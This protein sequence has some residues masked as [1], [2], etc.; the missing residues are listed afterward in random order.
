MKPALIFLALLLL[1]CRNVSKDESGGF[2]ITGYK[3]V[4]IEKCEYI[5]IENS[6][7]G[8]NNYSISLT[9]KGNCK[10]HPK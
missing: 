3:T 7:I 5:V 2:K 1:G 6:S 9:H 4:I 10:N 8:M